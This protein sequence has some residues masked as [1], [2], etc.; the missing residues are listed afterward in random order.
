MELFA[1]ATLKWI[2][3]WNLW[4]EKEQMLCW[5]GKML[6]IPSFLRIFNMLY[7]LSIYLIFKCVFLGRCTLFLY[8]SSILTTSNRVFHLFLSYIY[9]YIHTIKTVWTHTHS[10]HIFIYFQT[11]CMCYCTVT[12]FIHLPMTKI[13]KWINKNERMWQNKYTLKFCISFLSSRGS[14]CAFPGETLPHF[15]DH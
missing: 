15:G 10:T 1:S 8:S 5:M 4:S 7:I 11:I 14:A 2:W 12:Y 13:N 6:V 3:L 9:I